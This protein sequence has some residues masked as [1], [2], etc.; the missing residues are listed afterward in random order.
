MNITVEQYKDAIINA[1]SEKQVKILQTLLDFPNSTATSKELAKV[2]GYSSYHA[3]NRQIGQIGKTIANYVK[4]T[5]DTYYD[6]NEERPAYFL[7]VGPYFSHEGKQRGKDPGWEMNTNLQ[8]ALKIL[9]Q[10]S[11]NQTYLFVWNSKPETWDSLEESVKEFNYNGDC[12]ITW[13]CNSKA[14]I[15]GERAFLIKV[16][17]FPKGIF[18]SGITTSSTLKDGDTLYVE[19]KLDVLLHPLKDKLLSIDILKQGLL[20]EQNWTPQAS[21]ISI[22][23]TIVEELEKVWFNFLLSEAK[24]RSILFS[25]TENTKTFIEGAANQIT[26]TKYERN[27]YARKACVEH[28]GYSCFVCNFNFEKVY[29]Q[30]G[31]DFIHV[32]HLIQVATIGK[33]YTIDPINDLRPVCPNCHAMLHKANP[34]LTIDELKGLLK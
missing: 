22:K 23:S 17:T 33:S 10:T 19:I 11:K 3:A 9:R 20:S 18:G 2:L 15:P 25:D 24:F 26:L 6:G 1:L 31:K 32:H 13:R 7:V 8:T 28:Y 30:L 12:I 16:G 34:C 21:C 14:I 27:P 29:G 5:P 4:I